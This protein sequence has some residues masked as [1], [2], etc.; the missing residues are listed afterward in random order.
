[1]K[2]YKFLEILSENFSTF[3]KRRRFKKFGK[4]SK[5]L[6][7]SK[8]NKPENIEVGENVYISSD[9]WLNANNWREDDRAS[10]IINDGSYIGRFCQINAF[11]DVI[12]E[13][14]VL[15]ADNVYLGDVDHS[16]EDETL[17][18]K[19]NK[20]KYKGNILLKEGSFICRN[21]VISANTIVG[22]NS[23]VA[24]NTYVTKKNI[25]DYHMAIG[26]PCRVFKI[27]ND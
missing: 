6:T 1:M 27:K 12:I 18:I 10:L 5:I 17:A 4:N 16:Y 9:V 24:P 13:K 25:P 11:K 7:R 26:N 14:N 2:L 8:L 19:Q 21:V 23:I 15:I 20:I 3:M 22:K